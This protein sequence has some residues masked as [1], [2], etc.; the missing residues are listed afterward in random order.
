[1]KITKNNISNLPGTVVLQ[2]TSKYHKDGSH[3]IPVYQNITIFD[4]LGFFSSIV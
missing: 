3:L 4:I 2:Q 1:M